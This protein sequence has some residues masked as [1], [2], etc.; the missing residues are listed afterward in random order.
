MTYNFCQKCF[1]RFDGCTECHAAELAAKDKEIAR[2]KD[3]ITSLRVHLS[4]LKEYVNDKVIY[5]LV[6]SEQ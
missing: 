3:T 2:L 5:A 4:V 6:E 1:T